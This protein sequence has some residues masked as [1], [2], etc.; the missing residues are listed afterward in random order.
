MAG[1][2]PYDPWNSELPHVLPGFPPA[3]KAHLEAA[4]D[5]GRYVDADERDQAIRA[6]GGEP[7]DWVGLAL[8]RRAQGGA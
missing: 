8:R 5:A 4:H 7:A 2:R 6:A 1:T 3:A